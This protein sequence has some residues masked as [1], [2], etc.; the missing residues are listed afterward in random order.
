MKRDSHYYATLAFCRACGFNKE[1]AH[2]VAYASQFVDDAKINTIFFNKKST[3][4][5]LEHEYIERRP[6]F[7]NTA[8][9]HSYFRMDTFNYESMVRN[10]SAFHFV[11]GCKGE[12][13]TRKLRCKE[14]SPIILDI[15][16][17]AL[18]EDDLI[19]LGMVLHVYVDTFSHQGF[20]GVLSK[21]NAIR[22]CEAKKKEYLDPLDRFLK[23]FKFFT[24]ER[25]DM[26]L[27]RFLPAYGHAQAV[28]LPDLPYMEWS[29]KYDD[30]EEFQGLYKYVEVNNKERYRR[31]FTGMKRYLENYL[32]NHEH[33]RDK[34]LFFQ[35]F[36]LLFETMILEG[37][38]EARE[39]NWINLYIAEG[40]FDKADQDLIVY[41]EDKWLK[42]AFSNYDQNLFNNREVDGAELASHFWYSNWYRFYLAVKWYKERFFET[43]A[44]HQLWISH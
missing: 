32:A 42:E 8:T 30:S 11:P 10:T 17:E 40:L 36:E 4:S 41:E 43:C 24:Q 35:N 38:D 29:Y 3:H 13:F 19:K 15:V 18:L 12:S 7:F 23:L 44:K 39:K 25:Y 28:D 5:D 34:N 22:D 16:N 27:D 20:S 33:Y 21:V 2:L 9:C 31:A 1:S 37:S 26:Y 14:E 6:A